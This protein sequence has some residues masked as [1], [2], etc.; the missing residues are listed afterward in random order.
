MAYQSQ[1]GRSENTV[2]NKQ[3]RQA[4]IQAGVCA[5]C[6]NQD[7]C[8]TPGASRHPIQQCE[9][10]EAGPV[11]RPVSMD[12]AESRPVAAPVEVHMLGLCMNCENRSQCRLPKP[13]AGVWHC[14]EYR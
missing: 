7:H 4:N 11:W 6:S 8:P 3:L 12:V 13:P 10:H 9:M 5:N 1:A 14:E 2:E